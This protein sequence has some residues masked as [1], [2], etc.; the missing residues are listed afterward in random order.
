MSDMS[1][2]EYPQPDLFAQERRDAARREQLVARIAADLQ[3]IGGIALTERQ[4]QHLFNIDDTERFKRI[5]QELIRR[6]VV[7]IGAHGLIVRGDDRGEA[8]VST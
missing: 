2:R 6:G 3:S 4:A 8:K 5:L 1:Q 7:K